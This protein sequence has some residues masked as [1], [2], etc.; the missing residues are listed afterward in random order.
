MS[1]IITGYAR[2][3]H[4][5]LT[6]TG[7]TFSVPQQE[8]FT[9]AGS[10]SWTATD[11]MESEIGVN[12]GDGT[13]FIRIGTEIRQFNFS[14][15]STPLQKSLID[16]YLTRTDTVEV[17]IQDVN[18][19]TGIKSVDGLTSSSILFDPLNMIVHSGSLQGITYD[20]D[21]SLTFVTNSLVT[22]NYVDTSIP[23]VHLIIDTT[24]AALISARDAGTLTRGTVY[25][26]TDSS[27]GSVWLTALDTNR[28]STNGWRALQIVNN[29]AYLGTSGVLGVYDFTGGTTYVAENKVVWGGKIWQAVT[30]GTNDITDEFTL[31]ANW[32]V[33]T[34]DD[35]YYSKIFAIEYQIDNDRIFKQEDD[36]NNIVSYDDYTTTSY[37]D[38]TDWGYEQMSN[39]TSGGIFNNMVV[40]GINGQPIMWNKVSLTIQ[41][42][43]ASGTGITMNEMSESIIGNRTE[44]ILRNIGCSI[45]NNSVDLIANNSVEYIYNNGATYPFN[46][47]RYNNGQEIYNNNVSS[48]ITSNTTKQIYDNGSNVTSILNNITTS[49]RLNNNTGDIIG[50]VMYSIESNTNNGAIESNS[51][52]GSITNNSNNGAIS[53]NIIS[54]EIDSN[55]N[56]GA[57]QWNTGDWIT[58]N[59]S[60]SSSSIIQN[61][62]SNINANSNAGA[63]SNN[64]GTEIS[65][66]TNTGEITFNTMSGFITGNSN[67]GN[68]DQNVGTN[69]QSNSNGNNISYNYC[70]DTIGSNSNTVDI[71]NNTTTAGILNNISPVSSISSNMCYMINGNSNAGNIESNNV[72]GIINNNSN[73]DN[74]IK[75]SGSCDIYNNA[76]GGQINYN[77]VEVEIS[78]NTNAGNINNNT[79]SAIESNSNSSSIYSNV[80]T[81]NISSNTITSPGNI[82][83]N[84]ASSIYSNSGSG[85]IYDND[86]KES[87]NTNTLSGSSYINDNIALSITNNNIHG[88][89]ISRNN[90]IGDIYF[91]NTAIIWYNTECQDGIVGNNNASQNIQNNSASEISY[92]TSSLIQNNTVIGKIYNNLASV[93]SIE[94]NIC[95]SIENNGN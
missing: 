47:I 82:N 69:I 74:I 40:N 39:N 88:G 11:L 57:I 64:T 4:H 73:S 43:L 75:N 12:E 58:S 78:N 25:H 42:N 36:R 7:L 68:I 41:K 79:A 1:N 66:N 49:I 6:T 60:T 16:T 14:T 62:V 45:N 34:S 50:N 56:N 10:M 54:Q 93:G 55:T 90:I 86:V 31:N 13:A 52:G 30:P 33:L 51:G 9:L 23:H 24:I 44:S 72:S 80:I 2:L 5:T 61:K 21:Y 29:N 94:N 95:A 83:N 22:K 77:I 84:K 85:N 53:H 8:D 27:N 28:L 63:I 89:G 18:F 19:G 91:N 17:D 20:A 15:A 59:T 71:S 70:G 76:N 48:D 67:T 87:I 38:I 26:I 46:Q 3:S 65:S 81:E 92:N 37:I 35:N 32:T